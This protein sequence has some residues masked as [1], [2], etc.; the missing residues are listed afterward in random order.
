M[1]TVNGECFDYEDQK[2]PLSLYGGLIKLGGEMK[3]YDELF[4][5]LIQFCLKSK[6]E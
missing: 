2:I 4:T 1:S 3:R 6:D 5:D